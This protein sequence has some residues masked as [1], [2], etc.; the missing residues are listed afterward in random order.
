[1]V[2]GSHGSLPRH[3]QKALR[4]MEKGMVNPAEYIT[5]RFL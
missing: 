4:V 3:H 5:H 2:L 1:M